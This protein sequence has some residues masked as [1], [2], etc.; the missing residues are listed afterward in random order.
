MVSVWTI[1]LI[2]LLALLCAALALKIRALKRA[3]A[4][5]SAQLGQEFDRVRAEAAVD[6]RERI[7]SDLHDDLGA[8]LLQIVYAA[9]STPVADLARSALQDLRDVVTRSRGEL[10]GLLDVLS[11]IHIE[12]EQRLRAAAIGLQWEQPDAFPDH[13]LDRAQ[14]L[15]LSR[16]VREAVSNVIRHASAKGLRVRMNLSA[17]TLRLELSD[18]GVGMT[19]VEPGRGTD[20]MR[21]RARELEGDISWRDGSIGGTRV[22]LSFPLNP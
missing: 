13:A 15:H 9:S 18:D 21:M 14:A 19:N 8:K 11:D 12:T 3:L 1:G 2:F 5:R 6:E 17:L 7:F 4:L 10:G 20:T 22:V 16:I